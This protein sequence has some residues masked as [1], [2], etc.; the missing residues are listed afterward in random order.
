MRS[1]EVRAERRPASACNSGAPA[2]TG[3]A[4]DSAVRRNTSASAY[5]CLHSPCMGQVHSLRQP[6]LVE[7]HVVV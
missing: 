2:A 6:W 7:V 3:S 5:A 1:H 4:A